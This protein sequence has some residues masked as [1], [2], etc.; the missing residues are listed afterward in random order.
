MLP[1]GLESN[2][3]SFRQAIRIVRK[4]KH[5]VI[6]ATLI[7]G[8]LALC[9]SVILSPYYRATAAIEIEKNQNDLSGGSLGELAS[10][11][12]G[13]DDVKT[14]IQTEVSILESDDLGIETIERTHF[15]DH[16]KAEHHLFGFSERLP[17]ERG[18]PL[19]RAPRA[20]ETLLKKFESNLTITPIPDTRLIQVEFED[21][22]AKFAADTTNAFIDQYIQDRLQRRNSSTQQATGWMSGEIDDLKKQVQSSQQ[23][24]IDYQRQS[25]LIVM[26]TASGQSSGQPGGSG[27]TVTSPVLDRLT[28]LNSDLVAAE[29]NRIT[30][31]SL[32]R[33]AQSGNVDEL[34]NIGTG[35]Q[36]SGSGTSQG[37]LFDGL[38]ALR[39]QETTLSLQL[40]STLQTY[41]PKNPHL[42]DLDNQL[43]T[44]K[45]RMNEEVKRIVNSTK[46]NYEAALQA[47]NGVRTVYLAEEQKAYK[48]NDSAIRLAVLQQEADS[49]RTLYEDLYTKLQES[50]LSEGTQSSNVAIISG[51]LIPYKPSHPKKIL[52]TAIGLVAGF[53]LG[54]LLAFLLDS[55]DDSVSSVDDVEKLAGAPVL[56]AIPQFV[57]SSVSLLG[58]RVAA[59]LVPGPD[60]NAKRKSDSEVSEAYRTLRTAILLSQPGA[61]PRTLLVASAIPGE[62]KTTTCYGLGMC[63]A[64]LG[65]RVLLI[66]ADMRRPALH[67]LANT[68]NKHGLSTLLTSK[69][70]SQ[71]S[72]CE[73]P[74]FKNLFILP[75]GPA[76]PNPADLLASGVFTDL[77]ASLSAQYDLVLID[78]PPALMVADASIVSVKVDQVLIVLRWSSTPRSALSRVFG[79]FRRNRAKVLGAVMNATDT[80]SSEYYYDSGYYG[81]EYSREENNDTR[82]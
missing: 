7:L 16:Q 13:E 64:S 67:H 17:Q 49:T 38:L 74:T 48:M 18:L 24:L 70:N 30:L 45:Q 19:G 36:S 47:E 60:G 34:A 81:R 56:A 59:P 3:L 37:G 32:Y 79:K 28:Q 1:G 29:A 62:G 77:L 26:P 21:P 33:L 53:I 10:T 68:S 63:F 54:V 71:E 9:M 31:E 4:R 43:G 78:T 57:G 15:E 25:G 22:D 39:L 6:L 75:A 27:P 58:R 50:K 61:Q 69:S 80:K 12:S 23:K 44:L 51:G 72:I 76:P 35:L 66:D 14:Q 8:A 55:L 65:S 20:R 2:D 82:I 11:L 41:G 52:N 40:A 46:M 42:V 73:D 5:V